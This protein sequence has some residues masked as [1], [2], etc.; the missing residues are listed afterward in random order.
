MFKN[1]EH[2]NLARLLRSQGNKGDWVHIPRAYN[3]RMTDSMATQVLNSLRMFEHNLQARK[4][5]EAIYDCYCPLNWRMPSRDVPWMYDIR[6]SGLLPE[7]QLK[8]VR[9][10]QEAGITGARVGFKPMHSQ[11]E[12]VAA[13]GYEMVTKATAP[14][15]STL[16]SCEVIVLPIQ[17]G[18]TNEANI[19]LA[20]QTIR[21]A[22]E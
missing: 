5:I 3:Y 18:V 12:Y 2:A 7:Q 10:L 20:F 19:K 16:A 1:V 13:E 22:L 14:L 21:K 15:N 11:Q 8:T 17:P 4:Q 6:I 9:A